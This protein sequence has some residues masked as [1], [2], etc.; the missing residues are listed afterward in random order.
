MI[1]ENFL[2]LLFILALL[3]S[4]GIYTDRKEDEIISIGLCE[5]EKG[6]LLMCKDNL[7]CKVLK[8]NVTCASF[9]TRE[10]TFKDSRT[11]ETVLR[12]RKR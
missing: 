2:A 12:G 8:E 6:M 7:E 1:G 4:F 5:T 3:I 9:K 11:L 10:M